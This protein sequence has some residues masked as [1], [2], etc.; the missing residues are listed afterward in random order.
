MALDVGVGATTNDNELFIQA[1]RE[2]KGSRVYGL[3]SVAS[4]IA[5]QLGSGDTSTNILSSQ[6]LKWKKDME[7]KYNSLEKIME[8]QNRMLAEMRKELRRSRTG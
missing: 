8:E 5:S 7:E 6:S 3:G 4:S 2:W 1:T